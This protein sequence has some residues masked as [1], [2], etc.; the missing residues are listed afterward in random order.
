[1]LIRYGYRITIGSDQPLPLVT[2][3]TA[4]PER[5]LDLR[6][7]EVFRTDPG[8]PFS[9]HTDIYGNLRMRMTAPA[10]DFTLE[11]DATIADHGLFDPVCPD[12]QE[13]PVPSLPDEAPVSYTH[14]TLPTN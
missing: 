11:S 4:R 13:M 7:P 10:G 12:A 2:L 14:L 5:R 9:V 3:M 6:A 8:V 1:M